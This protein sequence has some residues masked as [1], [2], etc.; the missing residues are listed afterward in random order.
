MEPLKPSDITKIALFQVIGL[1]FGLVACTMASGFL[2]AHLDNPT[3]SVA[4][5]CPSAFTYVG[6]LFFPVILVWTVVACYYS[7]P[8]HVKLANPKTLYDTGMILLA[9]LIGLP[10]LLC[11]GV[12]FVKY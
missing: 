4:Y 3:S 5:W 1:I 9:V 6:W 12:V 8:P 11:L 7:Y 2:K 10:V